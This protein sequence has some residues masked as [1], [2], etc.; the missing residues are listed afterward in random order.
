MEFTG[1][2]FLPELDIDSEIAILHYQRY[3]SIVN[4]C[5]GKVILDAAC[6]E[7]YGSNILA[8]VAQTVYG[9]D[10]DHDT[11]QVAAEKYSKENL[12]YIEGSVA[13]LGFEDSTF[14][15]VVS[16][17]T[18]EHV[19]GSIQQEFVKEIRRGLKPDGL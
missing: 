6:G 15:V 5:R 18:I 17:E 3:R 10:L 8:G 9:V 13:R 7:G 11:I 12:R 19:D 1:E 14:D 4:I 2:R 16:F